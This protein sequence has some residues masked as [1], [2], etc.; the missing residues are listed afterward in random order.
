LRSLVFEEEL[1]DL[2]VAQDV[3]GPLFFVTPEQNLY[4]ALLRFVESGY[5]QLPVFA[6]DP[7]CTPDPEL[8]G[9]LNRR[10]VFQAYASGIK[11]V[12]ALQDQDEASAQVCAL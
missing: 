12:R 6:A 5:A 11:K 2:V 7:G 3:M 4:A 1:F 8:L 9:I 10:A